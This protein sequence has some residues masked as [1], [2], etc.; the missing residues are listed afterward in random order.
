M[1]SML[2]QCTC[3]PRK[4]AHTVRNLFLVEDAIMWSDVENTLFSNKVSHKPKIIVYQ[5]LNCLFALSISYVISNIFT[6]IR[7]H[8]IPNRI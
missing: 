4:F 7:S 5:L 8:M 6:I 2:C 1:L 3:E